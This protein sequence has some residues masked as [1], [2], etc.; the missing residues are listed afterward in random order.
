MPKVSIIIP[1]WGEYRKYLNECLE[2]IRK[3]TFKDYEIIVVDNKTDLPSARNEGIRRAK[4]EYILPM[5]VDD[6]LRE[7]YLEKTVDKG[8]VVTTAHYNNSEKCVL[9][10]RNIELVDLKRT[11]LVI[12]CSLFKKSVWED[13]GGYDEDFKHGYE[14]WDFWIRVMTKGYKIT[15]IPE[16]LYEYRKHKDSMVN[17]MDRIIIEQQIRNKKY[18]I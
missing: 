16:P 6:F 4:G 8:D 11:N 3:Q 17:T 9:P 15:V 13:I 12:A 1:V 18:D 10:A 2:N 14:D 5:D 7:D